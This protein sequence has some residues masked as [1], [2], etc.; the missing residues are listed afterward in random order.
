M[1][2]ARTMSSRQRRSD[3]AD[4]LERV[5]PSLRGVRVPEGG[6][7]SH[8]EMLA[9]WASE[10]PLDPKETDSPHW[11]RTLLG[12]DPHD[13][14]ARRKPTS[15][16]GRL[17]EQAETLVSRPTVRDE[18]HGDAVLLSVDEAA[19]RLGIG[20]SHMYK[21]VMRSDLAS[22]KMGRSRRIP[23]QELERFVADQVDLER[24]GM[25]PHAQSA[26]RR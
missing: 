12:R 16:A 3:D 20:R 11:E 22:I 18:A 7:V 17:S 8:V 21:L 4:R 19:Q 9:R 26:P 23:V 1:T 15:E 6:A 24:V 5:A 25:E 2:K 14:G 10:E 13:P